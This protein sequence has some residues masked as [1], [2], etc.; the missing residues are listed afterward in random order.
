[1]LK[2]RYIF[3]PTVSKGAI[4]YA[5]HFYCATASAPSRSRSATG[6]NP[7]SY[8]RRGGRE[9]GSKTRRHPSANH[10]VGC[11]SMRHHSP[12][13]RPHQELHLYSARKRPPDKKTPQN[14]EPKT[15]T[16]QMSERTIPFFLGTFS[17]TLQQRIT[18]T[19]TLFSNL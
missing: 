9:G 17:H 16:Q 4:F 13:P 15:T 11:D 2:Y 3:F 14:F 6:P 12:P 19:K 1:M 7:Y 5:N 10:R 18:E 8:L